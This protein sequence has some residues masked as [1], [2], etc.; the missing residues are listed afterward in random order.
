MPIWGQATSARPPKT[1]CLWLSRSLAFAIDNI[2]NIHELT[3]KSIRKQNIKKCIASPF[4]LTVWMLHPS[5][6]CLY[7]TAYCRASLLDST[8][9]NS[10]HL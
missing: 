5:V 8:S 10:Q 1:Y 7:P 6:S 2:S 9:Q 3:R 4:L